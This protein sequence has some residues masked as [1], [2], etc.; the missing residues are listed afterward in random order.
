MQRDKCKQRTTL[1][2]DAKAQNFLSSMTSLLR[3]KLDALGSGYLLTHAPMD[4]DL[5]PNSKY[6][7]I[8]KN[9]N[10]NLN[11]LM[12]QFY[13]GDTRPAKDGV[14][15]GSEGRKSAVSVFGSLAKDLFPGQP[16][17]VS[18]NMSSM[19]FECYIESHAHVLR[20]L[21]VICLM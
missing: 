12:P 17:K 19:D 18:S 3:K 16:H 20:L 8:L 15:T 10:A 6:Y 1:Y 14:A 4:T 5:A 9:Q 11:F 2:T 21:S 13:N 7:N